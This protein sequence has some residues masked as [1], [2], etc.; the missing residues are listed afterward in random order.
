MIWL[1][2]LAAI[3]AFLALAYLEARAWVWTLAVGAF[4]IAL[5]SAVDLSPPATNAL[6]WGFVVFAAILNVR[7][8]RRLLISDP[9]LRVFRKVMPPMSQTEADAINAGTVGWDGGL[10]SGRPD[11]GELLSR[12]RPRR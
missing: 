5:A 1:F 7:P 3:A 2:L 12:P 9:L 11:W 4:L 8:L 10:F 6:A